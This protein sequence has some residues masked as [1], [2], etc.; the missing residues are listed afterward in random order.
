[1]VDL[2]YFRVTALSHADTDEKLHHSIP[3]FRY[4]GKIFATYWPKE[5]WE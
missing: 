2:E 4:K 5:N 1:M 3:S